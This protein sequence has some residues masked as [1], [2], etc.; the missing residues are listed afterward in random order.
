MPICSSRYRE[1][2]NA[3]SG[4]SQPSSLL[5][6]H[7]VP[8]DRLRHRVELELPHRSPSCWRH[9]RRRAADTRSN[10]VRTSIQRAGPTC[11]SRCRPIDQP[12]LADLQPKKTA[13]RMS[14]SPSRP[15]SHTT[16]PLQSVQR[17]RPFGRIGEAQST[18]LLTLVGSGRLGALPAG[19][20]RG[21]RHRN[22]PDLLS[23]SA[24]HRRAAASSCT[25][26][27]GLW[28]D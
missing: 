5:S 22:S 25:A 24:Q 19:E 26:H 23:G 28:I 17:A 11:S 4:A 10:S 16:T 20:Y 8:A 9:P 12:V 21:K 6:N 15:Q 7:L 1:A 2:A 18:L 27:L 3:N 13:G 14:S